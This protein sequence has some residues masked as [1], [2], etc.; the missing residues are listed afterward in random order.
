MKKKI[1]MLQDLPKCDTEVK[2]AN[3]GGQM[4]LISF[5]DVGLLKLL[6]C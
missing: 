4:V 6:I 3:T 2:W 1:E 5:L